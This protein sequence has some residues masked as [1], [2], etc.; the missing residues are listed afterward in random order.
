MAHY[1]KVINGIVNKV[2]VAEP[3]FFDT[4]IDDSSGEWIQTSYNTQG[5]VHALGGTPL[6]KNYAVVGGIY[7]A[8]NDA[9]CD[10][11]PFPSWALNTTTYIWEAP[12]SRPEGDGFY[13]WDEENSRWN[14]E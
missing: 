11:Q 4:Y 8:E 5:G 13:I 7:D 12:V 9:F 10:P 2:I 1:A 14:E 3:D 6:R